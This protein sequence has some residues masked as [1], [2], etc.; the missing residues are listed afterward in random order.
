MGTSAGQTYDPYAAAIANSVPPSRAVR[1]AIV[2]AARNILFDPYS[3]RDAQISN[4]ADFG[5][6]TQGV[7]V[8]ANAKNQF[9]GY[10]GRQS[11]AITMSGSLLLSQQTNH[12]LCARPDVKWH[13]FPELEAL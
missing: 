7:C 5:N 9:G 4:V 12:P 13:K 3:V 1:A 2:E 11:H 6:G 10:T 8:L